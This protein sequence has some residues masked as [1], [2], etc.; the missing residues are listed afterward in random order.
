MWRILVGIG[1]TWLVGVLPQLNA[2]FGD[3]YKRKVAVALMILATGSAAYAARQAYLETRRKAV[4]RPDKPARALMLG[5]A[6]GG[7]MMG[8]KAYVV[9]DET[10]GVFVSQLDPTDGYFKNFTFLPLVSCPDASVPNCNPGQQMTK[11]E[12]DDLEGVAIDPRGLGSDGRLVEGGEGTQHRHLYLVAS[13]SNNKNGTPKKEREVL[14]R[15][16]MTTEKNGAFQVTGI[17]NLRPAIESLLF[18]K[19]DDSVGSRGAEAYS[20]DRANDNT[21]KIET[22]KS[23]IEIE[24][25]AVDADGTLYLGLRAPQCRNGG[26]IIVTASADALFAHMPFYEKA[27][28]ESFNHY[29]VG[30]EFDHKEHGIVSMEYDADSREIAILTGSP[31][32][33]EV[34]APRVCRWSR[35]Q[36][37][38][39]KGCTEL[40]PL[41]EQEFGKQE[42]LLLPR[43]TQRVT[44]MLDSD[45]GLGGQVSY[46]KN[47][48][49]LPQARHDVPTPD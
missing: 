41:R 20:Y 2:I 43:G 29:C 8:D 10:T 14:V 35:A 15:V 40:P 30:A 39:L 46:T 6:S 22:I 28:P 1:L 33:Y 19:S 34:L 25:L 17:V 3:R 9:N 44:T 47:E 21:S 45:K 38:Q 32:P 49:G 13:H 26:A 4:Y 36:P 7:S 23:G 11:E 18:G 24:G 16:G 42:V 5:E 12:I 48:V 31:A 37:L 27:T